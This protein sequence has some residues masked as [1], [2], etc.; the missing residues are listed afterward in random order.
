MK[1]HLVSLRMRI[2]K[3]GASSGAKSELPIA[4]TSKELC[5]LIVQSAMLSYWTW[6]C[7]SW[8]RGWGQVH[9]RFR[10]RLYRYRPLSINN[11]MAYVVGKRLRVLWQPSKTIN[12]IHLPLQ[13]RHTKKTGASCATAVLASCSQLSK[14]IVRTM[15]WRVRQARK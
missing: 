12:F 3:T 14:H 1:A 13:R 6:M 8:N 10:D 5:S 4:F 11:N 9:T 15:E 2:V 7:V